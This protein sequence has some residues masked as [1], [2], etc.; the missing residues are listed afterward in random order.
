MCCSCLIGLFI[1]WQTCFK[2]VAHKWSLLQSTPTVHLHFSLLINADKRTGFY[3]R[4]TANSFQ[5]GSYLFSPPG[6]TK[7]FH[8]ILYEPDRAKSDTLILKWHH[9]TGDATICKLQMHFSSKPLQ[10]IERQH[11]LV[12]ESMVWNYWVVLMP[13]ISQRSV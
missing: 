11:E 7:P 10:H 3:Q 6:K 2:R 5:T 12:Y 8:S 9:C 4:L 13:N 1:G